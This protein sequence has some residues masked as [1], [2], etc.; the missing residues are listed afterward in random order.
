[1]F[2]YDPLVPPPDATVS[3][4]WAKSIEILRRSWK[5]LLFVTGLGI[6]V[7]LAAVNFVQGLLALTPGA[8]GMPAFNSGTTTTP[9]FD[10]GRYL[11]TFS[12]IFAVSVFA[13]LIGCIGW[14]GGVYAMNVEATGQQISVGSALSYGT[15]RMFRLAG[16]YLVAALLTT[17]GICACGVGA[18]Y[19]GFA[20]SMF[21]FVVLYERGANPIGRSFRL[22]HSNFGSALGRVALVIL[23]AGAYSVVVSLV[24]ATL[25]SAITVSAATTVLQGGTIGLGQRFGHAV[26]GTAEGILAAPIYVILLV[27]LHTTYAQL[28]AH[29]A[30]LTTAILRASLDA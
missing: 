14:A 1:M 24:F 22:T 26:L 13:Y 18:L 20:V 25:D 30:P 3:V 15:G 10:A 7:P 28:R 9:T 6:A 19:L 23:I 27:G 8:M 12:I 29:E 21:S 4:W 11:S 5:T 2:G 17:V 16:W